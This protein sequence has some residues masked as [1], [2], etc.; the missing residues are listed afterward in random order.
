MPYITPFIISDDDANI[1]A[2]T[3]KNYKFEIGICLVLIFII[4]PSLL[5]TAS[6][7]NVH[8]NHIEIYYKNLTLYECK[9]TI[10]TL[11]HDSYSINNTI[12]VSCNYNKTHLLKN[13]CR[14][15]YNNVTVKS[16]NITI[17]KI[18]NSCNNKFVDSNNSYIVI[19]NNL[20]SKL[21]VSDNYNATL[22][23]D[24]IHGD[25]IIDLSLL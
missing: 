23:K 8:R 12:T 7:L 22:V 9:D 17:D 24:W 15:A 5:F 19:R 13:Y 21:N 11:T 1:I 16:F 6:Y 2:N 4:C 18:S 20:K 10:T 25:Y 14:Y 3:E